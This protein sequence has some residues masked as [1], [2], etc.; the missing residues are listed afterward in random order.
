[1]SCK[2]THPLAF[3][4]ALVLLGLFLVA[5]LLLGL[6]VFHLLHLHF[7]CG[8]GGCCQFLWERHANSRALVREC[9]YGRCGS[10]MLSAVSTRFESIVHPTHACTIG[11]DPVWCAKRDKHGWGGGGTGRTR[12]R[13][14]WCDG[15]HCFSLRSFPGCSVV[16]S[17]STS[18]H[19]HPLHAVHFE[20]DNTKYK[21]KQYHFLSDFGK[22][23]TCTL[24]DK[25]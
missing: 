15:R 3:F 14:L 1:M 9:V 21:V 22:P 7:G 6:L 5:L 24:Q 2:L 4:V 12:N 23:R 16:P 18:I 13:Y 17:S 10:T 11:S 8:H 25:L 20:F 19:V